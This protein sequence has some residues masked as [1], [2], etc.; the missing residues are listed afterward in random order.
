MY[1]KSAK[2]KLDLTKLRID[3]LKRAN[4]HV[5]EICAITFCYANVNC[6]VRVNFHDEKQDIFFS[7]FQELCDIIDCEV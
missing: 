1:L 5:K 2:V 7:T 3:L 6:R 4:N